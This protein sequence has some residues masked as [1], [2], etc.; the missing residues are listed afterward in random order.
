ML[1]I[2]DIVFGCV[3]S[4]GALLNADTVADSTVTDVSSTDAADDSYPS[5]SLHCVYDSSNI[6]RPI[7]TLHLLQRNCLLNIN[8]H[9]DGIS[10]H[11]AG[12]SS[13]VGVSG[14]PLK[15]SATHEAC[16]IPHKR[17]TTHSA[18]LDTSTAGMIS[19][20]SCATAGST[21]AFPTFPNTTL[22]SFPPTLFSC[23]PSVGN[24]RVSLSAQCPPRAMPQL[25]FPTDSIRLSGSAATSTLF[26][27]PVHGVASGR[28]PLLLVPSLQ[29]CILIS[30]LCSTSLL[31]V[32]NPAAQPHSTSAPTSVTA[33]VG[34]PHMAGNLQSN[35]P[36]LSQLLR[37]VGRAISSGQS[38]TSTTSRNP[39]VDGN[40]Q[41]SDVPL[42]N[43]PVVSHAQRPVGRAIGS[44]QSSARTA[45]R[46]GIP[47]ITGNL[48]PLSLPNIPI[49]SHPLRPVGGTTA[50]ERLCAPAA[51]CVAVPQVV[52]RS[53]PLRLPL[54]NIALFSQQLRPV[55]GANV[56]S[57]QS[58]AVRLVSCS[59]GLVP[60][61]PLLSTGSTSIMT[62]PRLN[63]IISPRSN[64]II[65]RG[66]SSSSQSLSSNTLLPPK[67]LFIPH[68][69]L[70]R[71]SSAP[72]HIP[73][74]HPSLL[75]SRSS[76]PNLSGN[77]TAAE[78]VKCHQSVSGCS[79]LSVPCVSHRSVHGSP[80]P[81]VFGVPQS[82]QSVSGCSSLSV[83]SVSHQSVSHG[84][85]SSMSVVSYINLGH[86]SS[87]CQKSSAAGSMSPGIS[88]SLSTHSILRTILSEQTAAVPMTDVRCCASEAAASSSHG[89]GRSST[90][91][92]LSSSL[93]STSP[94]TDTHTH[95]AS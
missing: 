62:Q 38:A 64:A 45:G 39:N 21:S 50:P 77:L 78:S 60:A 49:L 56:P 34:I 46:I 16:D 14:A 29:N 76:V 72:L 75:T 91:L 89:D 20:R 52:T 9:A 47:H 58:A 2:V 6:D 32:F 54:P 84:P 7:Q 90:Q 94:S 4:S 80:T 43:V 85:T 68:I 23:F 63:G 66:I 73:P 61:S 81:P 24:S 35:I 1:L 83:P 22:P 48:Q 51:S 12:N 36:L 93:I 88:S 5:A 41:P 42:P 33:A 26:S 17:A 19:P 57:D 27:V 65:L 11:S 3:S 40:S 87:E 30:S 74:L 31:C 86:E 95:T 18:L 79:S 70:P 28:C 10:P 44:V 8:K 25:V 55:G 67:P 71:L 82:H 59:G 13:H 15:R 53:L 37:P 92:S 69:T